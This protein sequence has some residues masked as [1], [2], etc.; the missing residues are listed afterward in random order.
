VEPEDYAQRSVHHSSLYGH[1]LL[2]STASALPAFVK[3]MNLWY[4]CQFRNAK[5]VTVDS[6][7]TVRTAGC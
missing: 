2:Y 7:N 4:I 1:Y 3:L 6:V 5:F